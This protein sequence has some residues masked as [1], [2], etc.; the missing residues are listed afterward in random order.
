MRLAEA[1]EAF[2]TYL[3][4]NDRSPHT[5]SAYRRDLRGLLD[6]LVDPPLDQLTPD[7]IHGFVASDH[8]RTQPNGAPRSAATINRT[9]ATLRAFGDWLVL[10][11]HADSNPAAGLAIHRTAR[12]SPETFTETERKRILRAVRSR[13]GPGAQRDTAMLELLLGT[14]IRLAELVGLDLGDVD[15]E[16]KRIAIYAKGGRDET[17]FLPADLRRSLRRFLRARARDDSDSTALFLSNRGTRISTRQVQER[18][19]LWLRWAGIERPG[20][21]VHSCRHTF[22]TRLYRKTKDLVLVGKAMGHR[23]AEATAIYVHT[24]DDDLEDAL[25]EL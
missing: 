23:T 20:L 9:K 16:R 14:G 25:D 7:L 19:R 8:C 21:S 18:F 22:G 6:H 1:I 17:R 12:Q 24:N 15:L 10:A 13:T 2:A 4:A 11:G 3:Q 5:V